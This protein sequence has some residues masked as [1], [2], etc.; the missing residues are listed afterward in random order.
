MKKLEF[1]SKLYYIR[2]S[3]NSKKIQ[4]EILFNFLLDFYSSVL[5]YKLFLFTLATITVMSSFCLPKSLSIASSKIK[6]AIFGYHLFEYP[7]ANILPIIL[8]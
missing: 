1:M 6:L 5:L 7:L 4:Q 8:D 3:L 2:K